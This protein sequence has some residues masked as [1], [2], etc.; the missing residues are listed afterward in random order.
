MEST[1]RKHDGFGRSIT[2]RDFLALA[3]ATGTLARLSP[4][5]QVPGD[6]DETVV[7][8]RPRR[9]ST[10]V[11]PGLHKLG[12]SPERDGLLYIPRGHTAKTNS[13]LVI[14]LHGAGRNGQAM[15]YT[16]SLADDF[17]IV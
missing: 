10:S 6:D 9:P 17:G 1:N 5:S 15:D 2:R 8:A 7:Q 16:F 3:G 12:L 4:N 14:M 11:V 13:P